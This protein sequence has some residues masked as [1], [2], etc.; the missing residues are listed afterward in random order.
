LACSAGPAKPEETAS[1]DAALPFVSSMAGLML[2]TALLRLDPPGP[3]LSTPDNHWQLD[4]TLPADLWLASRHMTGPCVHELGSPT[5][6][7]IYEMQPRRWD[8]HAWPNPTR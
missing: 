1:S 4:M 5:R 8:R 3:F 6:T 7:G 2:A